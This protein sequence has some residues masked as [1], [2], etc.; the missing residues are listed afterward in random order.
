MHTDELVGAAG[1]GSKLRDGDGA[2]VGG[3]DGMLGAYGLDLLIDLTLY[4]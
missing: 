1:E 2:G 3:D 4:G